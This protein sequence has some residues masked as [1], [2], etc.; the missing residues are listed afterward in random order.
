M[1]KIGRRKTSR[2]AHQRTTNPPL[3]A[4]TV[5]ATTTTVV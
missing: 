4:M 2:I 1:L 3:A 5:M